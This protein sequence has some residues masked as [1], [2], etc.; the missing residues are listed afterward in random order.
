MSPSLGVFIM[1]NN[2]FHDVATALLLASGITMWVIYRKLG[3]A[4]E[5]SATD[6]FLRLYQ[7]I[8][9]LAKFSLVWIVIGGIPR[10]LAYREFEWANAVG[11]SQV[12]ALIVKH[13]LAFIFVGTGAYIWIKLSRR[14]REIKSSQQ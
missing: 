5:E 7:S 2:Y 9:R 12:P 8:T 6:Y 14:V 11:K 1:M 13:I 3:A 4:T 10:T